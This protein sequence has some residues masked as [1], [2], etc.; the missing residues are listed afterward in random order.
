[1]DNCIVNLA[2]SLNGI[3]RR[4]WCSTWIG[5]QY[6]SEFLVTWRFLVGMSVPRGGLY[7]GCDSSD[8]IAGI[9]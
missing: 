3:G 5:V 9:E 1:M 2:W 4:G 6:G 8:S 7:T